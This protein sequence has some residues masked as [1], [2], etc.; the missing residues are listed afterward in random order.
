MGNEINNS[1]KFKYVFDDGGYAVK[2]KLLYMYNPN[3]CTSTWHESQ[4]FVVEHG[5]GINRVRYFDNYKKIN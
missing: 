5:S 1:F 4:V 3:L 2:H